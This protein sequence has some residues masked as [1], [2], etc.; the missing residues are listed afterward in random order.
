MKIYTHFETDRLHLKATSEE[1]APFILALLNMPKWK[2]FIGDRNVH[3]V[4]EA[5]AYIAERMR[6]QLERLGFSNYTVIR[7][8]D[9]V[10]MGTCGL[11][12]REGLTGLDIGFAFLPEFEGQGYAY[13]SANKM[14]EVAKDLFGVKELKAITGQENLPSQKLLKKLGFNLDGKT[15]LKGEEEELLLYRLDLGFKD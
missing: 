2:Q 14:K 4:A 11:Y 10:K 1:D 6:P 7:K 15:I 12:D 3:T 13:E 5:K 8:S 9:R